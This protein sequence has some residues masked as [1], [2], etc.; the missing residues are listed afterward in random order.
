MVRAS[1]SAR[2]SSLLIDGGYAIDQLG[3]RLASSCRVAIAITPS[4]ALRSTRCDACREFGE[5][6]HH[7]LW[8]FE[9][10]D[11]DG[12]RIDKVLVAPQPALHRS[13]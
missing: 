3:K 7:G 2:T 13:V 12:Q 5:S 1:C 11:I 9:I 4:R 8:R 6:F 10:I